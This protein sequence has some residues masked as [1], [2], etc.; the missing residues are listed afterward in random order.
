MALVLVQISSIIIVFKWWRTSRSA[1]IDQTFSIPDKRE[2]QAGQ[3]TAPYQERQKMKDLCIVLL[4]HHVT[5]NSMIEGRELRPLTHY[6][7]NSQCSKFGLYKEELIEKYIQWN[8]IPSL[9]IMGW[10]GDV[11]CKLSMRVFKD[12]TI[13]IDV[14]IMM[15]YREPGFL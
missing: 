4:K 11:E 3:A 14:A 8:P 1:I 10:H 5:D 9:C 7:C 12:S 15:Q 2:K 13:Y 6:K